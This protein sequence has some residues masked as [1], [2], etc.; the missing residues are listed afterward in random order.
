MVSVEGLFLG[1]RSPSFVFS[2]TTERDRQKD[3]LSPVSPYKNTDLTH[4]SPT[5]VRLITCSS[6]KC[7]FLKSFVVDYQA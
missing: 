7:L 4:A 6:S 3:D 5:R 2:L 1:C